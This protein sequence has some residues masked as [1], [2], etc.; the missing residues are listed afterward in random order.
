MSR[1]RRGP[2]PGAAASARSA[3]RWRASSR[4]TRAGES[5]VSGSGR[6]SGS[7]FGGRGPQT[8]GR[9]E[10]A[11]ARRARRRR[12]SFSHSMTRSTSSVFHCVVPDLRRTRSST[13][14]PPAGRRPPS[15]PLRPAPPARRWRSWGCGLQSAS[16]DG[17]GAEGGGGRRIGH[18][19]ARR[20]RGRQP[21]KD[22]AL[23]RLRRGGGRGPQVTRKLRVP[24]HL[25][26]SREIGPVPERRPDRST[27]R[28]RRRDRVGIGVARREHARGGRQHPFRAAPSERRAASCSTAR[29]RPGPQ[30][31]RDRRRRGRPS[32]GP[33]STPSR[34]NRHA[35]PMAR[36][37][38]AA[39]VRAFGA[40]H[41]GPRPRRRRGPP[42]DERRIGRAVDRAGG[43]DGPIET[44]GP[45]RHEERSS[46]AAS[47]AASGA[48]RTP[49]REDVKPFQS[50]LVDGSAE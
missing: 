40:I 35:S 42:R 20:A 5:S 11:R 9:I 32:P 1:P 25:R 37:R 14:A 31:A 36:S 12:S 38:R 46:A 33:R 24:V 6:R 47:A 10:R 8:S 18:R 41:T 48:G 26:V 50:T 13:S 44:A 2:L 34:W 29:A 27:R 28:P 7:A 3:R 4:R 39:A 22:F 21:P 49:T 15:P 17:Q 43:S 30:A 16:L 45:E 23:L 19:R